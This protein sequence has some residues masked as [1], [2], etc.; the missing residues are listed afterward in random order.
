MFRI[1][2]RRPGLSGAEGSPFV[3]R[4][5]TTFGD[6][7]AAAKRSRGV[8]LL[9]GTSP[10]HRASSP[11][12]GRSDNSPAIHCWVTASAHLEVP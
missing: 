3:G 11:A 5:G 7:K 6:A 9:S 12:G 1:D 8:Q 10:Q 4:N 2:G